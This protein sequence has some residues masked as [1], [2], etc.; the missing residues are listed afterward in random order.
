MELTRGEAMR[1]VADEPP[2]SLVD[3]MAQTF[4]KTDGDLRAVMETMLNSKEFW[5]EGAYRAIAQNEGP[6]YERPVN[7]VNGV[8]GEVEVV[9]R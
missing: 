1:F 9:A 3:R 5:S 2:A 7:V 8:D 4:L 6:V